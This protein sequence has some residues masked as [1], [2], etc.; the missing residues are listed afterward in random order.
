MQTLFPLPDTNCCTL[1]AYPLVQMPPNALQLHPQESNSILWKVMV[2][3]AFRLLQPN[4]N[5]QDVTYCRSVSR[6][7]EGGPGDFTKGK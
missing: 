5:A 1:L 7:T 4:C 6:A 2:V 3:T